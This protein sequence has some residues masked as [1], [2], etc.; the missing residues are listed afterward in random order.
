MMTKIITSYFQIPH[1]RYWF[2]ILVCCPFRGFFKFSCVCYCDSVKVLIADTR[3]A[4]YLAAVANIYVYKTQCHPRVQLLCRWR[5]HKACTKTIAARRRIH[6]QVHC[7]LEKLLPSDG[8]RTN[9]LQLGSRE[10]LEGALQQRVRFPPFLA[11]CGLQTLDPCRVMFCV[12]RRRRRWG[13][14]QIK[15]GGRP[16][17]AARKRAK[18]REH[19][20]L[21]KNPSQPASRAM[22]PASQPTEEQLGRRDERHSW[23]AASLA[24]PPKVAS[25]N[26]IWLRG[27]PFRRPAR[28]GGSTRH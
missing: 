5:W 28:R 15:R 16:A 7:I 19:S 27:R 10:K 17:A 23:Q 24:S 1:P 3:A 14:R 21:M 20:P 26:S 18:P 13:P 2:S 12:H 6:T 22:S 11:T 8:Y 25:H 4:K 9:D